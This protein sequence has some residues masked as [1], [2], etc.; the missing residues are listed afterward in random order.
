LGMLTVVMQ[1]SVTDERGENDRDQPGNSK[2]MVT[3]R[4]DRKGVFA[5]R[6]GRPTGRKAAA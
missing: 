1:Q 5:A 6:L 4:T 3:N 2:A